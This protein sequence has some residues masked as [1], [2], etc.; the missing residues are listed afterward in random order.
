MI[1][2]CGDV[3]DVACPDNSSG[4]SV[5]TGCTCD[6]GFSG[7]VTATTASPFFSSTCTGRIY[8]WC[9]MVYAEL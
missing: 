2:S 1:R 7:S 8:V 4:A 5:V 3:A 9:D 6:A